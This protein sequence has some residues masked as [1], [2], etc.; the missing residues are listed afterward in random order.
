MAE[1]A[2]VER[3]VL[4]MDVVIVGGG[5]AGLAAAYHLANLVKSHNESSGS[6]KLDG[7][8]IAVLEKG[9]EIGSHAI[10]GAVMDPRGIAELM[11]DWLER[12]CPVQSAVTTDA[13]WVL[14]EQ[15]KL[16][17]PILPPVL[18]QH[19]N[20]VISLAEMVRW[21]TPIVAEAG[22][23]LFPEFPASSVIL[24]NGRVAGVR[25]ADKG[26]DKNGEKKSN[27]EPGVDIRAKLVIFA[28][29]ARG[30][31]VKE[32][33]EKLDLQAGK[34][35]QVYSIG[36]KEIWEI[37]EDRFPAGSVVHTMGWPLDLSTFGG[38]FIYGM[39][40]RLV[41]IGLVI[42]LDYKNPTLDPHHEFQRFKLHPAI[43]HLL[44]GGK[45]IGAGAKAI[46]EGG[47]YAMPR[48]HGDGFMIVGDSGGFLNGAR[49]KGIHLAIASGMMAATTALE[50]LLAEDTSASVL[51]SYEA[52]F[53]AS[54]ARR[55]LFTQRNFHQGFEHGQLVGML[56]VGLGMFSGGRGF[57]FKSKLTGKA[58]HERMER[59]NRFFA[60]E[61]P[62]PP[63][64]M[65]FDGKYTFD[66][67]TDVYFGGVTHEENQPAHLLIRDP[68]ICITKCTYEYGNPCQHFCPAAVYEPKLTEDGR[69]KVPFLN[70][71][72]CFHCKTCDIM[73]PYQIITWVPP[74]GGGGPDYKKL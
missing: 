55:E 50:A 48:L 33:T 31:L 56:N 40:D 59:I 71:T 25:T 72:N 19:G 67:V 3:E 42:G 14:T 8:S 47:Y 65:K 45:M 18:K 69:G 23:D 57:G 54:W 22:V 7:L 64:R 1:L 15:K 32:L 20:Y 51:A 41:D 37:P 17:A 12:G 73:D 29:G 58:G 11:P 53:E 2:G 34:N 62:Q 6:K 21:L 4:E 28:E 68:E 36:V 35:P 44:E 60:S 46:P 63:E 43:K 74:E 49:L 38:G 9:R 10:S 27:Y 26:I 70:F 13:L 52:N 5:P 24:E 39:K 66:K 30:T 16:V 61:N